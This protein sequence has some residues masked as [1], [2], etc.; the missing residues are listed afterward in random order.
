MHAAIELLIFWALAFVALCLSVYVLAIFDGLIEN[1]LELLSLGKEVAIAGVASFIEALAVWLVVLVIQAPYRG[2]GLR[3]LILPALV[4][5]LIYK[6]AHLEHWSRYD[7][8]LLLLF[9]MAIVC[10]G[11]SLLTAHFGSAALVLVFF[12]LLLAGI[13]LLNKGM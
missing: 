11:A 1:D 10:L 5:A 3:A 8:L 4:V 6:I 7:V 2:L 9:Q 12:C 13:A